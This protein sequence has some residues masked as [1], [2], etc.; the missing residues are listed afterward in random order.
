MGKPVHKNEGIQVV[1]IPFATNYRLLLCASLCAG[2]YA[3]NFNKKTV[4]ELE[5]EVWKKNGLFNLN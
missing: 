2:M 5:G 1:H 3:R 4:S